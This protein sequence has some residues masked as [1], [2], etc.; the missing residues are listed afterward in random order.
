MKLLICAVLFLFSVQI[1][2]AQNGKPEDYI[3]L[4]SIADSINEIGHPALVNK[5]LVSQLHALDNQE[6]HNFFQIAGIMYEE[7]KLDEAALLFQIAV[8]RYK[9][10]LTQ[11]PNYPPSDNWVTAESFQAVYREKINLYLKKNIDNY[12]I[13]LKYA[14][15]YHKENDYPI[16]SKLKN[17]IQYN[18]VLETDSDLITEFEKN[19]EKYQQEWIAERKLK[20][21]K[22]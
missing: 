9:Y 3:K 2:L 5:E 14:V 18:K 1:C 4:Y 7:N 17:D 20:L 16:C 11:N 12:L 10:Y 8:L 15:R 6:P 21:S 13:I 22:I 19:K